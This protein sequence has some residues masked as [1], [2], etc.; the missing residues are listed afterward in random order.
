MEELCDVLRSRHVSE[1]TILQMEQEKID[2][3]AI[4]LMS[5]EELQQYLPS[6]GDRVAV[7]GY[8]RRRSKLFERL[9]GKMKKNIKENVDTKQQQGRS[10]NRKES[11]K[12]ELGWLNYREKEQS[13]VQIRTKKGG[14]TQKE[15]VPKMSKKKDLIEKALQ[16]FF[17]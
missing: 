4:K 11:R 9:K 16:L 3:S 6:Y 7:F 2:Q 17:P 5:D 14:G 12:I 1:E 8:C 13:F 15:S 10:N